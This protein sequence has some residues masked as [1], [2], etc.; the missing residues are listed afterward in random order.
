APAPIAPERQHV[1]AGRRRGQLE[2]VPRYFVEP[3]PLGGLE[4]SA[5]GAVE[6]EDDQDVVIRTI[7]ANQPQPA[8]RWWSG[9]GWLRQNCRQGSCRG[10]HQGPR[11]REFS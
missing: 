9:F 10:H 8:R 11:E 7:L 2:N 3:F 1:I 5:Q 4:M 6:L